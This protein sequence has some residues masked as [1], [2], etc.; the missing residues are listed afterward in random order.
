MIQ[1]A[2]P[3]LIAT[4]ETALL[5]YCF[6]IRWKKPDLWWERIDYIW[7]SLGFVA[8]LVAA[9]Q[10]FSEG[11]QLHLHSSELDIAE[12][13]TEI[14]RL[15]QEYTSLHCT[16]GGSPIC[17][18]A[19]EVHFAFDETMLSDVWLRGEVLFQHGVYPSWNYFLKS[20]AEVDGVS[21]FP[22]QLSLASAY[23]TRALN[24]SDAVRPDP[25]KPNNPFRYF[26]YLLWPYVLALAIPLKITRVTAKIKN[27]RLRQEAAQPSSTG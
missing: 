16:S 6:I 24:L 15:S 5:H 12:A 20:R 10:L 26:Y 27:I 14:D 8:I 23:S 4:L 25:L 2:V 7:Y 19:R 9:N 22:D 21:L 11:K 3:I 18:L 13:T 17:T 1:I